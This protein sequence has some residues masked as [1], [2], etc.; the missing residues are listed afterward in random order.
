MTRK[1]TRK[2]TGRRANGRKGAFG[3][4]EYADRYGVHGLS[5][6]VRLRGSQLCKGFGLF[7][8]CSLPRGSV[9]T[10]Y[11]GRYV[12]LTSADRLS[13]RDSTYAYMLSKRNKST[14]GR[15]YIVGE[16]RLARLR[17]KGLGQFA[18]DAIHEEVTGHTNNC[19]FVEVGRKVYLRAMHD[20]EPGEELL[21]SYHISY[22]VDSMREPDAEDRCP[23]CMWPEAVR[24]WARCHCHV[25]D[26]LVE[27]LRVRLGFEEYLG[28]LTDF[29]DG[30]PPCCSSTSSDGNDHEMRGVAVYLVRIRSDTDANTDAKTDTDT[31]VR[32]P[33]RPPC[34]C[35]V[36]PRARLATWHVLLETTPSLSTTT[37]TTRV[38]LRCERCAQQGF[39]Y[40]GVISS[41]VSK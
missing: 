3:T 17:G 10:R 36:Q 26:L 5:T 16:T 19:E 24:H 30:S 11:S 37:M 8:A 6:L 32:P 28:L 27:Q 18:N 22:W 29:C 38:S 40:V 14:G 21:V 35:C 33:V 1:M 15:L 20:I 7:A 39:T 9:I 4:F 12:N 2:K 31:D 23:V 13:P 41:S 34:Q 25:Q